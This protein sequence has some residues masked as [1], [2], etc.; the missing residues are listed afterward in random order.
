MALDMTQ[1]EA[2]TQDYWKN[3]TNDIYFTENVMLYKLCGNGQMD[4]NMVK[5]NEIVDGG[6][7][8]RVFLEHGRSNVGTYGNASEIATAKANII[9]AAR[10]SWSGYQASN[11]LTLD[12][13]IQNNGKEAMVDLA[14]ASLSNIQKSI[15]DYMGA[16]VYVA[17]SASPDTYGFDGLPD[18][19]NT[20]TSTAYGSIAEDD[21]AAWKANVD[22]TAETLNYKVMQKLFRLATI[23]Q[24]RDAKPDLI[25]T[26]QL[27]KDGYIRTLQAQQRFTNEKLAQAGFDNILHEGC[28]VVYDDN[29]ATGVVDCLNTKYLKIKAHK[30]F[31]FTVPKWTVMNPKQPHILTAF[32]TFM[33][34]MVC[35]NRKANSRGS[36]KTE[37]A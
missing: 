33:G 14:F 34:A 21:M 5:A 23:G 13:Q 11:T 35:S 3:Q 8:I 30:D 19:F 4:L 15:R 7:K 2:I 6:K 26:T 10:F 16:G 18:L 9:N 28:P 32:T 20:T 27:L 12:D 36:G 22:T 1:L 25:V 31:N 24:S 17:R 29:Q 37:P